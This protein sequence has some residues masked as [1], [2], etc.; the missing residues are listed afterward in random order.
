MTD[1]EPARVP[2]YDARAVAAAYGARLQSE[3][4]W[5]YAHYAGA[6]TIFYWG[7]T[8][9][10][11]MLEYEWLAAN[12][13]DRQMTYQES[14][15]LP[16]ATLIALRC[17]PHSVG[18]RRP[19]AWGLHDMLSNAPE[20]CEDTAHQDLDGQPK[21]GSPRVQGNASVRSVRGADLLTANPLH[22]R[23]RRPD[24]TSKPYGVRLV[25]RIAQE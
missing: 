6:T 19:N 2:W 5:E 3:A 13:G 24:A 23:Q 10:E 7:A 15:Q 9:N 18:T 11:A 4:E 16:I 20:W 14:M 25:R 17:H 1:D 8:P 12:S 21:D 22:P